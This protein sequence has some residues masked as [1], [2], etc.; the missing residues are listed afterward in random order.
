MRLRATGSYLKTL[1]LVSLPAL[2]SLWL[3]YRLYHI[4]MTEKSMI[5]WVVLFL[6]APFTL[7]FTFL[8]VAFSSLSVIGF[9]LMLAGRRQGNFRVYTMGNMNDMFTRG[10]PGGTPGGFKDVTPRSE[11]RDVTPKNL[12]ILKGP[13][14]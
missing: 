10:F 13:D 3:S 14:R 7:I 8:A 12:H 9:L 2:I 11:P 5:A 6:S 4:G 1:V